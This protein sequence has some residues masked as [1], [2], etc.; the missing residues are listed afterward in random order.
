MGIGRFIFRFS[1]EPV[2]MK[3][4]AK[5][6][7]VFLVG[8]LA[9]VSLFAWQTIRRQ[10]DWEE[11][12][13]QSHAQDLAQALAPAIQSAYRKGGR[14]TIVLDGRGLLRFALVRQGRAGSNMC[15]TQV[16][17]QWSRSVS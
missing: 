13:R 10:H 1:I 5:L 16:G 14:V 12:R 6:I 7:L 9:I 3:L 17:E 2:R 4:A 11:Q 15:Q 8:V